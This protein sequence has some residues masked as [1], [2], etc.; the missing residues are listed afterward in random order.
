[1][2][3][4]LKFGQG[5]QKPAWLFRCLSFTTR[6]L[7]TSSNSATLSFLNIRAPNCGS[8]RLG[9]K[10]VLKMSYQESLQSDM[11]ILLLTHIVYHIAKHFIRLI[12]AGFIR[13]ISA[14]L[15]R[16][17]KL[18]MWIQKVSLNCSCYRF[19]T[20]FVMVRSKRVS[21]SWSDCILILLTW[22]SSF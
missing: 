22:S 16:V 8:S 13:Q 5:I 14:I 7:I 6:G 1:M 19:E 10:I 4:E 9:R 12:R 20:S 21:F 11:Q 2:P 3:N 15:S 18:R 17:I